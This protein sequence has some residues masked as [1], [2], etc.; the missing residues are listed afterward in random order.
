MIVVLL[1]PFAATE[2]WTSEYDIVLLEE[3]VDQISTSQ[4][5]EFEHDAVLAVD[6]SLEDAAATTVPETWLDDIDAELSDV[7]L[8]NL[9]LHDL[10]GA[11]SD[12]L[13]SGELLEL[14][15][16]TDNDALLA[17]LTETDFTID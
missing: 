12:D 4:L 3:L 17:A 16:D 14:L 11:N 9:S 13:S 5:I 8:E 2:T 7:L 10:L 1:N 6:I 15:S